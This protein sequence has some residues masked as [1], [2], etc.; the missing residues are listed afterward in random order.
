MYVST[1]TTLA[2]NHRKN[3]NGS[4]RARAPVHGWYRSSTA[5]CAAPP[6]TWSH[7]PLSC[8]HARMLRTS[9]R[10]RSLPVLVLGAGE[11]GQAWHNGRQLG[12]TDACR[13]TAACSLA[14]PAFCCNWTGKGRRCGGGRCR[15]APFDTVV[16]L[17]LLERNARGVRGSNGRDES[18]S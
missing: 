3:N 17:G 11:R 6:S 5:S 10:R 2:R 7:Q 12:G 1:D 9:D 14:P 8:C 18:C 13:A 16:R 4:I 15:G